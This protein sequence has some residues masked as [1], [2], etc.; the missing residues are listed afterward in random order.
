M[1]I[2]DMLAV[3]SMAV[4]LWIGGSVIITKLITW[5]KD[6][7]CVLWEFRWVKMRT[8][9]LWKNYPE[10][11]ASIDALVSRMANLET[12]LQ[13]LEIRVKDLDSAKQIGKNK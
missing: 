4:V 3:A 12:E 9:V 11:R 7:N 6:I 10:N 8:D 13:F 2:T 1:K 5:V